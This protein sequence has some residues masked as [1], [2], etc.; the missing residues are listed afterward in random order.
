MIGDVH[1]SSSAQL[2]EELDD[3]CGL[4][5]TFDALHSIFLGKSGWV[6]DAIDGRI[7]ERIDQGNRTW[8]DRYILTEL[9]RN[10]FQEIE[11]IDTNRITARASRS[12]SRD[13]QSQR[14]S[15]KMLGDLAP[16]YSLPWPVANIVSTGALQSYKRISTFLIQIRRARYVL[17]RRCRPA[18]MRGRLD[19][20]L[21]EQH[22]A[23]T[24]HRQLL[25]FCERSL[26]SPD[27]VHD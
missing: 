13:M 20:S 6:W 15:V 1:R 5:R 3:E 22:L 11:S 17:E 25:I 2:R 23:Q 12:S 10:G 21:C 18:V 27:T 9:Y 4:W 24:M 14:R 16:S 7:F 26:R 19:V 8:N